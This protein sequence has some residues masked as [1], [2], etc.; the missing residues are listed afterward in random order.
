MSAPPVPPGDRIAPCQLSGSLVGI[1]IVAGRG[2]A[3]VRPRQHAARRLA[4]P[5]ADADA[6]AR[7][8]A[9]RRHRRHHDRAVFPETLSWCGSTRST[10]APATAAKPASAAANAGRKYDAR[11]SAY[12]EVDE[13]NSAIGVAR[14]QTARGRSRPHR[15]D[16]GARAERSLRSRRRS[17]RAARGPDESGALR[18]TPAQATALERA[19]D[20]LNAELAPLNSFVLP[21]G[22]PASAAL[23]LARAICRRAERAIVYLSTRESVG[24]PA[25]AY[26]NRLSD[27]LFV[28]ARFANDRG[29]SDVL[30]VPG[31]PPR[32]FPMSDYLFPP[33]PHALA[34]R[35]GRDPALSRGAHFLRRPQLRGPRPR[36]GPRRRPREAVL[37]RQ[38]RD[39]AA[40]GRRDHPLSAG[41]DQ[42]SLRG[43][44]GRRARRARVQDQQGGGA[45]R[46]LS[47][48]PSAS[49]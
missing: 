22:S 9:I 37:F 36:N 39:G 14:L 32:G 3:G 7:R 25:I 6:L 46:R 47:A 49:T 40:P 26:V 13:L 48:T 34:A 31:A 18:M 15:G 27:Y 29:A 1:A 19:I 2:R 38:E 20:D 16:A 42:L 44:T 12:G 21:G 30:W 8:P 41:H 45:R 5:L 28:A 33:P 43:R 11:V 4:E 24:A 10:P 23:H 35:A 17:L